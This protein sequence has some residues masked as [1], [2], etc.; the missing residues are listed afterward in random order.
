MSESQEL[1]DEKRAETHPQVNTVRS[2]YVDGDMTEGELERQLDRSLG[3]G[4]PLCSQ[5]VTG[6]SLGKLDRFKSYVQIPGIL[7]MLAI[8]NRMDGARGSYD[9]HKHAV[10]IRDTDPEPDAHPAESAGKARMVFHTLPPLLYLLPP[11]VLSNYVSAGALLPAVMAVVFYALS[12]AAIAG[13]FLTVRFT[14]EGVG[15]H[16]AD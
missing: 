9:V 11:T 8:L 13:P 3:D 1:Q 4:P 6:E 2:E 15:T 5:T 14:D 12:L 10:S 16:V 7:F